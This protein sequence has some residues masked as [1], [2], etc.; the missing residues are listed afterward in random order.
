MVADP[1]GIRLDNDLENMTLLVRSRTHFDRVELVRGF[2]SK[3]YGEIEDIQVLEVDV[4]RPGSVV[5]EISW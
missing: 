5:T 2:T 4:S 3:Y 1:D